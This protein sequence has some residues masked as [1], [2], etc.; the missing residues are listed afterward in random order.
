[1]LKSLCLNVVDV[2]KTYRLNSNAIIKKNW[3][4]YMVAAVL[5]RAQ[6]CN[7]HVSNDLLMSTIGNILVSCCGGLHVP[8]L[9]TFPGM[10]KFKGDLSSQLARLVRLQETG[11]SISVATRDPTE[12]GGRGTG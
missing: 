11:F 1:M 6:L 10:D 5:L 4:E 12:S 7:F 9:P 8:K 2:M 3:P